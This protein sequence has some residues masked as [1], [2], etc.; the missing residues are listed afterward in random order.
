MNHTKYKKPKIDDFRRALRDK[1]GNLNKVAAA[2]NV[3]RGTVYNWTREDPDFR[4]A[5]RDE[6]GQLFDECLGTARIVALGIPAY[7]YRL[8]GNGEAIRDE[9][10]RPLRDMV[11]WVSRPDPNMLRYFLEKL[12]GDSGFVSEDGGDGSGTSARKGVS[13]TAWIRKETGE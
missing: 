8:D 4:A 1:M 5:L 11:G 13:I 10:G 2:F 7:E 9:R 6:R 12:G 3:S